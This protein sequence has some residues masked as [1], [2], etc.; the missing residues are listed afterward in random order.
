VAAGL[1]GFVATMG[2]DGHTSEVTDAVESKGAAV[3]DL[4]DHGLFHVGVVAGFFA[5]VAMLVTA[6]GWRRWAERTAPDS[7]AARTFGMALFATAASMILGYGFKGSLAIYLPGGMDEG[8]YPMEGL[9]SVW[10]FLDFAPYIAWWGATVAAMAS[11]WLTFRERLLPRW[12]GA[13]G[14]VFVLAPVAFMVGTGLPGFPGVVGPAW[15]LIFSIGAS[16]RRS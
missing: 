14:V 11:V 5:V 10:M 2:T 3:L 9:Y 12:V 1:L 16:L 6:A 15:L 4:V 13:V 7:L 8:T